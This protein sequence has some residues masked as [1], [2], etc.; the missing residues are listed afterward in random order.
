MIPQILKP[1]NEYWMGIRQ[2]QVDGILAKRT[3]GTSPIWATAICD[4]AGQNTPYTKAQRNF[5]IRVTVKVNVFSETVTLILENV[6][7][8]M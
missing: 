2:M 1:I 7:Q 6:A 8:T 4:I 5:V 3:S